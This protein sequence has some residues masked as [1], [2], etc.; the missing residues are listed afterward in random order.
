MTYDEALQALYNQAPMFSHVGRSAYKAGLENTVLIDNHYRNPHRNYPTIHVA[1]TNGKGSTA[2]MIAAALQARGLSVGLYTSPHLVDF[3]ERIRVDGRNISHD[4]VARFVEEAQGLIAEVHPSF[5]EITTSLA[6]CYFRDM[7]VDVA[8]VE[9]GLG[10][11]F[12]CT[13]VIRPLVS[14]ITNISLEH[15]DLL[16]DT[17]EKIAYQKAGIIK[18]GVPVVVG[19]RDARTFPVFQA[20]ADRV[21]APMTELYTG[22]V[23]PTELEGEH[24]AR[25]ARTAF[26]A[27]QVVADRFNLQYEHIR[28]G[29][30]QVTRLTGLLGRWQQ[31]S[32]SPLVI[33]DVGHNP[34]CLKADSRRL[35]REAYD[36]LRIVYGVVAD[37]DYPAMTAALPA[38]ARYYF[39][40][41]A[42]PR[43][44]PADALAADARKQGRKGVV[45]KSVVEGY[46][47][48]LSDAGKNDMVLVC[49]SNFVVAE[50]LAHVMKNSPKK[51]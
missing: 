10:G 40:N 8:V 47:A 12:D 41:A 43:A 22:Q 15:T 31:L 23:P 36:K 7:M 21:G 1:G 24:Q 26:M 48:A 13:N 49:G 39:V 9:V 38:E 45:Y 37:K 30:A 33:A 34:A 6:F 50:V 35:R 17:V 3:A 44:L 5:F 20:E 4:Y 46:R 27:L 2:H 28:R 14:V 11:R 16:G 51:Q 32:A 42:I 25:N 18:A 19:E 29:F